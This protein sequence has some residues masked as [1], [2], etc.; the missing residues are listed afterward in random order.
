MS[1]KFPR[2]AAV[3]AAALCGAAA[4][5]S[6]SIK[7]ENAL[8]ACVDV[9]PGMRATTDGQ[10]LLQ[11]GLQVKQSIGSCGCKSAIATYTS[12]VELE[13]GHRSFLQSGALRVKQSGSHTL[14]LAS[15]EKLVGDRDVV[16]SLGC[17]A[18][19]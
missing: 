16:L 8:A 5:A 19:D 7:L 18:P 1:N 4:H 14:T 13:G 17:A 2:L 6:G 12:R 11:A 15:D 3:L 9:Q 10:V